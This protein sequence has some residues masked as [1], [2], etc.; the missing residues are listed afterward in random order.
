MTSTEKEEKEKRGRRG[1]GTIFWHEQKKCYRGDISLGFMP[2]GKRRR[3]TVYGPTVADVQDK[4]K[5]LRAELENGVDSS[6]KYTVGEAV[7]DWLSRGLIGRDAGTIEKNRILA[8]THVIPLLGAVKLRELTAD[9]VDDWLSD[10]KKVLATRSLKDTHAILRRSIQHAQ[11]RNKVMRNVAELV[12]IPQ[13]RPGRPS[14][15]MPLTQAQAVMEASKKTRLHAYFVLSLLT[16]VRTEEA[17]ALTW[18]RVHLTAEGDLPP[19]VEVWRSVRKGGDTK[20]RKSRR[21]L[22]L[23]EEVVRVLAA[24]QEW[25]R[26]IRGRALDRN[27]WNEN[28][29]VFCDRY[30]KELT[31]QS[32]RRTLAVAL[33][34]AGLPVEWTPRELRHSFVSLMSANGASIE[35]IAR[36]VGH[37][38]TATTEAVYR[39]ELRP[40]ITEGAEIIGKAFGPRSP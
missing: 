8:E 2:S 34:L 25:Q 17:R 36:L 11:R 20:T 14:K 38:T 24:H 9:H 30:G 12:D 18:D 13:G 33:R 6:A 29:L 37:T 16:G 31:A 21:T 5:K 40:V 22:A 35:L 19:H 4:F 39:H 23:P 7:R 10:R 32:V 15:A 27:R 1:E 3:K 26:V 28:N